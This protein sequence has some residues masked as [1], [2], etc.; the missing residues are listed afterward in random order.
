[1][2][3]IIQ[4]NCKGLNARY[5]EVWLLMNKIYSSCICLQDY[6]LENAKYKLGRECEFEATTPPGK[7][8]MRVTAIETRK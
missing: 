1:M 3:N 5:E 7:K 4:W 2:S 8:N 6:M